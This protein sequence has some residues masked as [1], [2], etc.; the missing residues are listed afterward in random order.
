MHIVGTAGHVDHGKSA[1]VEA[2]TGT[3]PDRW[4]EERLRGM[5]LDLGFA[6]LVLGDGIEAGIVDVPGHERF[7]HNMLAGA[8]GMELVLLVVAADEGVKPQTLEHL[9]I[10][11]FLNV[12]DTIVTVTKIDLIPLEDREA[13][14]ARICEGLRATLA[15]GARTVAVSSQTGE[16]IDALRDAIA[17]ALAAIPAPDPSMPAYLPI[18]RA[19]VLPGLGTIV[20]GTLVQGGI[21]A[22]DTLAI[23][24]GGAAAR[25]RSI[26]VFGKTVARADA[27]SRVALN[28][29]GVDR[30]DVARGRS[31][32]DPSF[33]ARTS[34]TVRFT[35][36]QRALPLLKRR[37][38]VRAHIGSA[39]V[40]GTLVFAQTP[41][42]AVEQRA[43]L[44]LR[45]GVAAFPG[46]RFVLR[47]PS[48]K[49][50]LGGGAIEG[51][52]ASPGSSDTSP[53]EAA[54]AFAVRER[55]LDPVDVAAVAQSVNAR[56]AVASEIL[57]A[58][59]DRGELFRIRR[60]AAY[61]HAGA[62]RGV[63]DG[64][65][66]A[67]AAAHREEPWALGLTSIA[68]SRALGIAE[69]LLVR[70][71]G[72]FVEDGALAF[73]AGYYAAV[74][75]KPAP[76]AQ[77]RALFEALLPVDTAAPLRPVPFEAIT[78]GVKASG[79]PGAPR[80]LDTLLLRGAIVKVGDEAYRGA[81]IAQIVAR[82]EQFL[83]QHGRMTAAEFRDLLGTSRKYAV[84]LL[85]W[86]DARGVTVRSGDHRMLRKRQP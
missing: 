77:Q 31:I 8:A 21:V 75:H 44:H 27:G 36:L 47:R 1:L 10:L 58:L 17:G 76:T 45:D 83:S 30:Q 68:L 22:G 56:E 26:Q 42:L 40:L 81:Q 5:T 29:P 7:L 60:P 63:L 55:G 46:V 61:L 25:V 64:A 9:E 39:E 20:T 28:L 53:L 38:P 4:I 23:A 80:A 86:L 15:D 50:L 62:A 73:G 35:P 16:G 54:I 85:E 37:T 3:H 51:V 67:L 69:P 19:F 82:V 2:L 24:P 84:P 14:L 57:D 52:A 34:V 11:Q 18:D 6:H 72:E 59:V 33:S 79:V 70:V 78:G 49:T 12:R 48:P 74:D 41:L 66:G 13:A 71:L 65:L 43:E 32:V